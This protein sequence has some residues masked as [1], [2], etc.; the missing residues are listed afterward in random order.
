VLARNALFA[1]HSFGESA[2]LCEFAQLRLPALGS[3]RRTGPVF[4]LIGLHRL[5]VYEHSEC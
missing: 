4:A 5:R 2:A 3:G 1:A